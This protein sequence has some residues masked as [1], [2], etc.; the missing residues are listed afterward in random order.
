MGESPARINHSDRKLSEQL[1]SM[2]LVS[3]EN[4][5]LALMTPLGRKQ[6][7]MSIFN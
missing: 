2:G 6:T 1:K 7:S 4:F 5:K 3:I